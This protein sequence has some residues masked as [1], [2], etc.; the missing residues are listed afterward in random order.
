[1]SFAPKKEKIKTQNMIRHNV[2]QNNAR[3]PVLGSAC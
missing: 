3:E 1:M 2:F